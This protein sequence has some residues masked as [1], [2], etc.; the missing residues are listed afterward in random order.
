MEVKREKSNNKDKS[1][2]QWENDMSYN[3]HHQYWGIQNIYRERFLL[4]KLQAQSFKFDVCV[5]YI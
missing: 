2:E 3:I 4:N 1:K 5:W